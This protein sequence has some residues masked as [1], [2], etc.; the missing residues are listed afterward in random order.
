MTCRWL[1]V[2][3]LIEWR[4]Q[5]WNPSVYGLLI[6]FKDNAIWIPSGSNNANV[7]NGVS[8]AEKPVCTLISRSETVLADW[9]HFRK[10]FDRKTPKKKSLKSRVSFSVILVGFVKWNHLPPHPVNISH[11]SYAE[12]SFRRRLLAVE[13]NK[14]DKP[15][16]LGTAHY[17][18]HYPTYEDGTDRVF[19]NVGIQQSDAGEI[20]KRIR[21]WFKTRRKFEIKNSFIF[22]IYK[23]LWLQQLTSQDKEPAEDEIYS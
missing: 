5:I 18:A 17:H 1:N 13:E 22:K 8:N 12:C 15:A 2:V 21:I 16:T 6:Q 10:G 20:P 4:A 11:S 3:L 19:R 23:R 14:G 9:V 7:E